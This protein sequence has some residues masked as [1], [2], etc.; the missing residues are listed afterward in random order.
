MVSITARQMKNS[1]RKDM[2]T[3]FFMSLFW[4]DISIT[5]KRTESDS[6]LTIS[7]PN[8]IAKT[9][10]DPDGVVCKISSTNICSYAIKEQQALYELDKDPGIILD[11]HISFYTIHW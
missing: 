10:S 7:L 3:W 8:T 5:Y 2:W 4:T 6:E 11:I 9:R 1:R